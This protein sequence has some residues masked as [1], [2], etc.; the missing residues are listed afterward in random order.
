MCP[1]TFI[2]LTTTTSSSLLC[3]G[4]LAHG[5][6]VGH[7]SC[8]WGCV[9]GWRERERELVSIFISHAPIKS[10][11]LNTSDGR[12]EL[13]L[14]LFLIGDLTCRASPPGHIYEA[15]E[16][17]MLINTGPTCA[18]N[19]HIRVDLAH[20]SVWGGCVSHMPTRGF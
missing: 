9:T 14:L 15:S 8:H 17:V 2:Q 16:Y 20:V 1:T 11:Y 4:L 12:L 13:L 5:P 7:A 18:C 6:F 3:R 10:Q 19:L